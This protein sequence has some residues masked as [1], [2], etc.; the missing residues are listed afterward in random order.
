MIDSLLIEH[1]GAK[2]SKERLF[3]LKYY[4]NLHQRELEECR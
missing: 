2:A 4:K 1:E 3:K